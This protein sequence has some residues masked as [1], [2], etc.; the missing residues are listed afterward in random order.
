MTNDA[1]IQSPRNRIALFFQ[2]PMWMVGPAL[3]LLFLITVVPIVSLIIESLTNPS[4]GLSVYVDLLSRAGFQSALLRTL[5]MM[6]ALTVV[7][8]LLGYPYAY[9]MTL[10]SRRMWMILA[11][12]VMLPLWTS[13]IARTFAWMVILA[14]HG[15]INDTLAHFGL[16]PVKLIRTSFGVSV[17]MTQLLLPFMVLP[18]YNAMVNVDPRLLRAARSLGAS[19]FTVFRTVYL[20]LT[21][22]GV[23]A[24]TLFVSIM[25]LG[26]Y[27]TPTLLGSPREAMIAQ[28]IGTQTNRLLAFNVAGA[29]SAI[30]IAVILAMMLLTA[31][32]VKIGNLAGSMSGM[33]RNYGTGQMPLLLSV[34]VFLLGVILVLPL[35]V[36]IVLS[37]P[38]KASFQFPPEAF[39]LRFYA[40][41]LSDPVWLQALRNT[42]LIGVSAA[43][44]STLS[45]ALA[46]YALFRTR[47]AG[48]QL[49]FGVLMLPLLVPAI[50]GAV[51][52]YVFFLNLGWAGSR[53]SI[54]LAHA[55][56][57]LPFV[58]VS[59]SSALVQFDRRLE[60]AA[61]SLGAGWSTSIAT[62]TLPLI[63]P[64]FI[65][66]G[67]FAFVTSFDEVTYSLFLQGPENRTLPVQMYM[68]ISSEIDPTVA[69]ASTVVTLITTILFL[70]ANWRRRKNEA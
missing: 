10:A 16:G 13:L 42:M 26:F 2:D 11:V 44:V 43:A 51:G 56:L 35:P 9:A 68:S 62:V 45:G 24:G 19:N 14:D 61:M 38:G 15:I 63:A 57:G 30:L 39:S 34:Y 47:Y 67:L 28:F 17:A 8:L 29:A 32:V 48:K 41:L 54:I 70:A 22:P 69:A 25:A 3:G 36:I 52:A 20:P 50:V 33:G 7:T 21:L 23:I 60:L 6:V 18:I 5:E 46:A 49:I 37:F 31:R 40:N 1:V 59:I 53:A 27:V 55:A 64:A 58:V 65:S 66:G 12:L 4:F